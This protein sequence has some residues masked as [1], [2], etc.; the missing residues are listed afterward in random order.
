MGVNSSSKT[1]QTASR[2][3][4]EPRPFR[5]WVQ[6]ANHSATEPPPHCYRSNGIPLSVSRSSRREHSVFLQRG[7]PVF[8]TYTQCGR[9]LPIRVVA[10]SKKQLPTYA[11]TWHCPHSPAGAAPVDR[12]PGPQHSSDPTALGLLLWAHAGTDGRTQYR[13]IDPALHTMRAV[14]I[15]CMHCLMRASQVGGLE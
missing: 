7:G 6:Q 5:A 1:Y 11:D 2:L 14:P 4:F 9:I 12:S 3:R 13:F 8:E 15:T 10:C